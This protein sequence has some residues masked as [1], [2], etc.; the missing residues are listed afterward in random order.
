MDF[1]MQ[2]EVYNGDGEVTVNQYNQYYE[3]Y[4]LPEGID[5]YK[6]PSQEEQEGYDNYLAWKAW[7]ANHISNDDDDDV[8]EV[9]SKVQK[10]SVFFK[11]KVSS[12][13]KDIFFRYTFNFW[14]K[15]CQHLRIPTAIIF[16]FKNE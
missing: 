1:N 12:S 16:N 14:I 13:S 3:E 6:K 15:I 4:K 2:N 5:N 10:G 11:Y 9:S 7:K 8:I